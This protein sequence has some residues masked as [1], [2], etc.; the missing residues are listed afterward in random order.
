[1]NPDGTVV[2]ND[3]WMS[4]PTQKAAIMATGLAP[5]NALESAIAITLPV[6][7]G[8]YTAIVSGVGGTTGVALVE[9]YFGD[10]VDGCLGNL[11]P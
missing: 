2:T 5:T 8:A 1:M 10:P 3:D 11:C 4:D 7:S 6:G 9:A